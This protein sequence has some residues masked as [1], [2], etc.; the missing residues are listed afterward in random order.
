MVAI[1]VVF[2]TASKQVLKSVDVRSGATAAEA[3]TASQLQTEFPEIEF[4][5]C[6]LGNWGHLIDASYVV[7]AG[8]RI[9]IYRELVSDP[10][11]ARRR[12]AEQGRFMGGSLSS[13]TKR[14][15]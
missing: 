15:L 1:E 9:E 12:L 14:G 11:D 6:K 4:A 3:V 5:E 10:R 8:D 13:A 2:A 7:S